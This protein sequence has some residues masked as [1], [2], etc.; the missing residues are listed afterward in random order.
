M[1]IITKDIFEAS[2]LL[3]MGMRLTDILGDRKTVL[4][5]FE[6]TKELEALKS[7]YDKGR[8]EVNI[9]RFR[10]SMN[11]VRDKLFEALE[12]RRQG[13]AASY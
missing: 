10:N 11:V 3:A 7:K 12:Q 2:Y 1:K 9:R 5:Q 13:A 8:A 4:F 6:G